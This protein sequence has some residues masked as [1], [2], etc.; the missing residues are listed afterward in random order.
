MAYPILIKDELNRYWQLTFDSASRSISTTLTAYT[1]STAPSGAPTVATVTS[2]IQAQLDDPD[3][4]R[5]DSAYLMRFYD[6]NYE[7]MWNEF[8]SLDLDFDDRVI[9]LTGV[10]A[11]TSDLSAYQLTGQPLQYMIQPVAL[12]WKNPGEEPTMYEGRDIPRVDRVLDQNASSTATGIAN[13]EF[14]NGIIYISPSANAL[15]IRIKFQ[16]AP[17]ALDE[18]TDT[19]IQG[20]TN[21]FV[22]KVAAQVAARNGQSELA[23]QLETDL[24]KAKS[25]FEQMMVKQSQVQHRRFGRMNRRAYNGMNW[26]T[27]S[28]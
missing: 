25:N 10:P 19:I 15:D 14:R 22:Y 20:T 13:Y 24:W 7:D 28:V 3:G 6:Q 4:S 8:A 9:E 1:D 11:N 17:S 27:P 23:Q 26:R 18:S 21:I 2:R 12:Q 16:S 5:F